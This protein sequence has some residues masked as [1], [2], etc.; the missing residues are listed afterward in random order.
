MLILISLNKVISIK[1][2][3][4][5]DIIISASLYLPEGLLQALNHVAE[6]TSSSAWSSDF[7]LPLVSILC[8][9]M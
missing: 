1:M 2:Q 3:K 7:K 4:K 6:E 9:E 8:C 5:A